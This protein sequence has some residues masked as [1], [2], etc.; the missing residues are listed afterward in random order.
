MK[1][2]HLLPILYVCSFLCSIAPITVYFISNHHQYIG[3]YQDVVKL[4]L[5]GA[6][7]LVLMLLKICGKL[8]LPS[9]T[10]VFAFV[11]GLSYLLKSITDDI[12]IFSF[13]ILMGDLCDKIIF[14]IP[15]KRI[16]ERIFIDKNANA[17]CEK[18]EEILSRYYRGG[19]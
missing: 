11:F 18:V 5:G 13:L 16:K 6:V 15:I 9:S 1:K 19:E 14:S 10:V 7:C 8:K 12:L 4:S 3:T 2:K 17:T